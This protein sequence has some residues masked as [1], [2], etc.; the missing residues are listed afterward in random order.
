MSSDRL[1]D[2]LQRTWILGA[3]LGR[4]SWGRSRLIRDSEGREAV[5][6]LPLAEVDLPADGPKPEP[7][8]AACRRC[9]EEQA[10]LLDEAPWPFLPRL[11]A[12][13]D[14]GQGRLGLITPRYGATLAERLREGLT[15]ED[16]LRLAEAI[17]R[18]LDESNQIHGNLKPSNVLFGEG[19]EIFLAD[20][21]TPA[22][23]TQRQRLTHMAGADGWFP[24]EARQHPTATW[25]TWALAQVLH[26]S[27]MAS[28]DRIGEDGAPA[29]PRLAGPG[30]D[31]VSL[32]TVKDQAMARLAQ[33]GSNPRF[34]GRV[35]DRL[36]A[37]LSRALSAETEPSPPYR[38]ADFPGFTE[39]VCGVLALVRPHIEDVG[40]ILLPSQA[41]DATFRDGDT[42]AFSVT[43][44]C[45]QGVNDHEDVVCGMQLV[46]LDATDNSR[47]PIDDAQFAVAVHPSGRLRYK[48]GLPGI[49][50]GRYKVKVA[51]AI[52]ES[53][54]DPK[55]ASIDVEVR[56]PPGYVPPQGELPP[57]TPLPFPKPDTP[58]PAPPPQLVEAVPEVP[59]SPTGDPVSQP[60][61]AEATPFPTPVAPPTED[62]AF[63]PRIAPLRPIHGDPSATPLAT[64]RTVPRTRPRVAAPG[65]EIRPVQLV[66]PSPDTPPILPPTPD[67]GVL[68]AQTQPIDELETQPL[69]HGPD[70]G[71]LPGPGLSSDGGED[72][73]TW[74]RPPDSSLPEPLARF[75]EALRRDTYLAV[76][77]SIAVCVLMVLALSLL[78][79][80]C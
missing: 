15:L 74:E 45:T 79:Q 29:P 38:F 70:Q 1:T 75:A 12:T 80:A 62:E 25:D 24:P 26:A 16:A 73:P 76:G 47:V 17:S 28:P 39:R 77:T 54:D 9:A 57:P 5:L 13:V 71:W 61:A 52:K 11:E 14:L 27:A 21:A 60:E 65:G 23:R 2:S 18:L 69:F 48:L 10:R 43:V 78:A 56:P 50:P 51:F 72:L 37:L 41:D 58:P 59:S 6:K 55:V 19:G 30:L 20:P 31:K 8:V 66:P 4:G 32:A 64:E 33:E 42:I 7:I 3:P 40:R 35:S 67:P 53:G 49:G 36:G 46:D 68:E 63:E 34:R 22:L 44:S